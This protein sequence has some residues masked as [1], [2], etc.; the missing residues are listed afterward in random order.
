MI[1]YLPLEMSRDLFPILQYRDET[2]YFIVTV[3]IVEDSPCTRCCVFILHSPDKLLRQF[4]FFYFDKAKA[5]RLKQ[6]DRPK[7]CSRSSKLKLSPQLKTILNAEPLN[8]QQSAVTL[9]SG[10]SVFQPIDPQLLCHT[11]QE[12]KLGYFPMEIPQ[13]YFYPFFPIVAHNSNLTVGQALF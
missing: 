13:F 5:Q 9:Y 10:Y 4:Y 1:N 8:P 11:F 12:N 2:F 7:T 6:T 3:R